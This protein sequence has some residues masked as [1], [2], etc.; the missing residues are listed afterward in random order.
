VATPKRT[1]TQREYDL[2]QIANLYLTG[3]YQAD[4][5]AK[6]S[7]ERP[8][9][10]T[11]QTISRDIKT[12]Q[13]RWLESSLVDFNK[14]KAREL[15][16]IDEL[17]I[18]YWKAWR[19]S[20]EKRVIESGKTVQTTDGE[21]SEARYREEQMLGNPLYLQGIQWCID[22]R[23]KLFGLDAPDKIQ[24]TWHTQLPAGYEPT[25]VQRQ[26]AKLIAQAALQAD[27][28]VSPG[29]SKNGHLPSGDK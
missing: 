9:T 3:W 23:C 28:D 18:T 29:N 24:H 10:I 26:F 7:Q 4:I 19:R 22:R 14:A 17:E 1:K 16:K 6:L 15:A 12:L 20:L 8:Y 27:D 25:E 11:R 21:K 13:E 5:A 2:Q